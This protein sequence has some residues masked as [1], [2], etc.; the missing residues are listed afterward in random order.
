M[1]NECKDSPKLKLKKAETP[2]DVLKGIEKEP[3][4]L[5][6]KLI[7]VPEL[8]ITEEEHEEIENRTINRVLEKIA[9]ES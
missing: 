7:K 9:K 4:I 2:E 6:S 5:G 8:M 3:E 1:N